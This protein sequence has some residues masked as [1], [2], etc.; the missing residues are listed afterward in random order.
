[1]KSFL[2]ILKSD[3]PEP[4]TDTTTPSLSEDTQ[5]LRERMNKFRA[6]RNTNP[7]FSEDNIASRSIDYDIFTNQSLTVRIAK[8]KDYNS[9]AAIAQQLKDGIIVILNMEKVEVEMAIR[10][11]EFLQG[12][13]FAL[14]CEPENIEPKIFL[15]DPTNQR[16]K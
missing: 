1:M 6:N 7:S 10:I 4:I 14:G 13:C 16:T 15:I 11:W 2:N 9:V 5:E 3:K 8:P 12:V